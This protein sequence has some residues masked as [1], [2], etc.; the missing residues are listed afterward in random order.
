MH[1]SCIANTLADCLGER[2]ADCVHRIM[3]NEW[4]IPLVASE[5]QPIR[6]FDVD[7]VVIHSDGFNSDLTKYIVQCI[8]KGRA[9]G[10]RPNAQDSVLRKMKL[11]SFQSRRGIEGAVRRSEV[12]V[13]RVIDIN[14]NKVVR[15]FW[16]GGKPRID[17]AMNNL[18]PIFCV[19]LGGEGDESVLQPSNDW[20]E[21]FNDVTLCDSL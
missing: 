6:L 21:V 19:Q 10:I 9:F 14:E 12:V 1:K 4:H 8:R 7:Q 3:G 13:G 2:N 15:L 17:I 11:G 16:L 20:L 5:E 18:Q